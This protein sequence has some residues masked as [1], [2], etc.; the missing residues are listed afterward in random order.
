M[1][2][3]SFILLIS[4]FISRISATNDILF[5]GSMVAFESNQGQVQGVDASK[6]SYF[7][8]RKD[9]TVFLLKQG[10]ISY[11][12]E[13]IHTAK[14]ELKKEEVGHSKS[15]P[16]IE[17]RE[18][19]RMDVLLEGA[20]PSPTIIEEDVTAGYT[21]YYNYDVFQVK[22]F[23]KIIYKNVYPH[24]DWVIYLSENHQ[25]KYD[26]IVYPKGNP[27]D[28]VLK[29]QW[30]ENLNIDT[31]GSLKLENRFGHILENSPETFQV[32]NQERI[33]VSSNFIVDHQ[34]IRFEVGQYDGNQTL[35]IDPLLEWA[36]Y[37]GGSG[38]ENGGYNTIDASGFIYLCGS[39]SSTTSI[40]SGGYQMTNGS[41][42]DA[43]LV[44]FN[45]SGTRIWAT[46]YGGMDN[47]Y[48]SYC[49]TDK[50]NNVY[51]CGKTQSTSSIAN[52]GH[53]MTHGGD[54][55]AFLVKFNA[56][57]SRIWSTYY[58]G[59]NNEDNS[60]CA[61]DTALNVYL[62]GTTESN[63]NIFATGGFQNVF[64]GL[65]D[66]Y[67]VKFNV[68]GAR[69]WGSFYGGINYDY[70][71]QCVVDKAGSV[72]FAGTTRSTTNI[73][74]SGFQNTIGGIRDGFLVKFNPSGTRAWA[75]YYG[76]TSDDYGNSVAVDTNQN[77]MLSGF[78]YS[79]SGIASG[80]F[81]NTFGGSNDAYLVKFNSSG[82]RLWGTY[83]GGS[84][85]DYGPHCH[86]DKSGNI[87]LT[88]YTLSTN[89]IAF[90]G[91]RNSSFGNIEGFITKFNSSGVRL[92]G[93]FYGGANDDYLNS[94]ITD[95]FG[96]IYYAGY[97]LSNT[98][99]SSSGFQN[100]FGGGGSDVF[101]VKMSEDPIP[102]IEILANKSDTICQ[103]DTVIFTK[104]DINGGTAPKYRWFRNTTMVDT[105][106]SYIAY[107]LNSGDSVR[108]LMIS[109]A[110][111]LLYDS[112]WSF[113]KKFYV[114]PK[115]FKTLNVNICKPNTY[116]FKGQYRNTAG[117]YYDTIDNSKGCDSIITLNLSINDTSYSILYDTICSNQSKLFN[118][119]L[120]TTS[121]WYKD[122]LTNSLGCDS[123]I[124]LY[125]W[126]KPTSSKTIDTAICF[127]NFIFFNGQNRTTTGTY[128]DTLINYLN[129]DSILT[130]NLTIKSISSKIIDT[131]ICPG[132][133][134]FFN[135]QNRTSTGTYRD[136]LSNY[137][138]CD[139]IVTLNLTIKSNSIYNI[140]AS[141][142]DNQTYLFKSQVINT[143]GTYR[144]TLINSQGCDSFVILTLTVNSRSYTSVYDTICSNQSYN[145]DSK[146]LNIAGTYYDTLIN[147]IGCDSIISL[148]LYIKPVKNYSYTH[149]SCSNQPYFF[150]GIWRNTSGTYLDTAIATNG[151]DSF[152]TLIL[153]VHSIS[154]FSLSHSICM[155]DS[156]F[157]NN[158]FLKSSGIFFDTLLNTTGCDSF[159]SLSL[160][161]NMPSNHSISIN[162][163]KNSPYFF[164]GNNLIY[165]GVYYDTL[166]NATGCDSFLTL[167][168]N[169]YDTSNYSF[170]VEICSGDTYNFGSIPRTTS[171][172]Y[173]IKLQ[174][175]NGCDSTL[176]LNLLVRPIYLQYIDTTI[177]QGEFISFDGNNISITGTYYDT[178]KTI[179]N[180][181]SIIAL[182][183]KVSPPSFLTL[184]HKFCDNKP[185][186]FNGNY[187][188]ISGN[189]FDTLIN[190]RGCDSFLTLVMYQDSSDYMVVNDTI[191]YHDTVQF[192][193][194]KLTTAGIHLDT[195]K[196]IGGCDS[197]VELHLSIYPKKELAI[198]LYNPT[199][200]I[201]NEGFKS[202]YWYFNQKL[203]Q[204][205]YR[206]YLEV[207]SIGTYWVITIDSN[208]C[209][210]ISNTYNYIGSSISEPNT[211][212]INIYPNP[213]SEIL[214]IVAKGIEDIISVRV[215]S[216]E[217]KEFLVY[218][219][220]QYK[221]Q[222]LID[223]S[224]L[225]KGVY[226]LVLERKTE[227][228]IE[229]FI[230][231]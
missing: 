1:F 102:Y 154:S 198:S 101:M 159:V 167:N 142:C 78:T 213:S 203:I 127:G 45:S 217:G 125:L 27:K 132:L 29:T 168:Y 71:G 79:T 15:Y 139:S 82:S 19:Y 113:T 163:C 129:C 200:I 99:I 136:T 74:G 49:I 161:V 86:A 44:K 43:F 229:K 110:A 165:S 51:L 70:G 28:I 58:G 8:K 150:N 57:G 100:T 30:V 134:I 12:F 226:S 156:F 88:G 141:I 55:D 32:R 169:I 157:F 53:Q 207:S 187:I 166:V 152:I 214:H 77:V 81:Q 23:R 227:L 80:G 147:A 197:I 54:Y 181:D 135:G 92:W 189:Y 119:I 171:G 210:Y 35:I 112:A 16:S 204:N 10:G 61:I 224:A 25:I 209:R 215:Y 160:I 176:L 50:N 220:K 48:G 151:C 85:G 182:R 108:C 65:T 56:S 126:V 173:I 105:T 3:N 91:L 36:T 69:Q 140:S 116:Y 143:S 133:S 95:N 114:N 158:T 131:S 199:V 120:R 83:Y 230:K 219:L 128:K 62:S 212:A 47:D 218:G 26:F 98:N 31:L 211:N 138:G 6:V 18:T 93:S 177:C 206:Y 39:T 38:S 64:G 103:G 22:S 5:Q 195:F 7:T 205:A 107:N 190:S 180:C 106:T 148:F 87:Y 191:C 63:N 145:F 188:S 42:Y 194:Q 118:S 20:N 34:Q 21:N 96:N 162:A 109:N 67:I 37:Y 216:S 123:F 130:L 185:V 178:L 94:S 193:A 59:S 186:F 13:K 149:T 222:Y 117:T 60:T 223:I 172:T 41:G 179:Y 231:E 66:A 225:P 46:Y 33:S 155:G 40:A 2:K 24:I 174:N 192:G 75:T 72:Y 228:N 137:L 84:N 170:N 73:S 164:N 183:L 201:S 68:N 14:S 97:T 208:Q 175:I 221:N 115:T 90:A 89:A 111:G 196:N 146:S 122:T 104:N 121:G 184:Y 11:Q 76:G 144:D 9:L 202:Y 124:Y 153:T 4:I 17:S 52:S